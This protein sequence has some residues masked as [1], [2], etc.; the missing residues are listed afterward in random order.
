[1]AIFNG[2]FPIL[3]G[4]EDAGQRVRVR[5]DRRSEGGIRRTP[6]AIEHHPRNVGDAGNPD[7]ELHAGL[8]RG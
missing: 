8:V 7:G 6:S 4:K 5:D 2:A 3:K 1:M